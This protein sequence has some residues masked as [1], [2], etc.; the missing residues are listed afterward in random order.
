MF[1]RK[2]YGFLI[3]SLL[4][5]IVLSSIANPIGVELTGFILVFATPIIFVC[6]VPV[7]LL[8]DFVTRLFFGKV[9]SIMAFIIHI[10]FGSLYGFILFSALE[11]EIYLYAAVISSIIFW[12]VDEVLRLKMK[13]SNNKIPVHYK[14]Y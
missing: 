12:L 14:M 8:S 9:R 5:A 10:S 7:S 1:R 13:T 3:T 2:I 4:T 6:G 11:V